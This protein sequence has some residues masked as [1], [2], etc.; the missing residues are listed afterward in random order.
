MP[1]PLRVVEPDNPRVLAARA[2]AE[3][4]RVLRQLLTADAPCTTSFRS[5][6]SAAGAAVAVAVVVALYVL[7]VMQLS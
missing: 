6:L 2:D 5:L 3:A 1:Y 7:V 4:L